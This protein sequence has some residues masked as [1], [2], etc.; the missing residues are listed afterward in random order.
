MRLEFCQRSGGIFRRQ[1][2]ASTDLVEKITKA[3]I[4]LHNYLHLT[5]NPYYIP[6]GF[7]DS[8]DNQ[9]NFL[10]GTWRQINAGDDLQCNRLKE[11]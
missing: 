10:P 7:V 2:R 11:L 8:E 1:I 6:A 5:E 4:C 3:C 9:G